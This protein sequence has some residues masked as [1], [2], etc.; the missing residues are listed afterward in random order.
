[1]LAIDI[2]GALK[3]WSLVESTSTKGR[4]VDSPCWIVDSF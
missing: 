3:K 4:L 1:M 2:S